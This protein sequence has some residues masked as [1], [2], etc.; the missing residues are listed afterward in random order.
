M[1]HRVEQRRC[2]TAYA[3]LR[4]GLHRGLEVFVERDTASMEGFTTTDRAA[5]RTDTTGVDTDAGALRNVFHNG[6]GGGVDGIQAVA[7]LDQHARAELAGRG[8]HA[9]HDWRR[10]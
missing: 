10:Q 3:A 2:T 7:A 5:Q 4:T 1:P 6:A 9:G 8:A